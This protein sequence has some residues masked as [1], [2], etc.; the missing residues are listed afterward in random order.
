YADDFIILVK[1]IRAGERVLKSI[2]QYLATK[3][4]LVVNEQKS[5][6]V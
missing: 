4:K 3:L 2:T 1:S 5:Q 6:V